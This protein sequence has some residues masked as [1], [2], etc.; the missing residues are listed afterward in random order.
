MKRPGHAIV[1]LTL[2]PVLAATPMTVPAEPEE[3]SPASADECT[4]RPGG[5][6]TQV[7]I[8]PPGL[9][10]HA[11]RDA[12]MKACQS[13]RGCTALIWDDDAHAPQIPPLPDAKM[14]PEQAASIVAMWIND[15][16]EIV[17]VRQVKK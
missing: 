9:E 16:Q 15:S 13:I 10:M 6:S 17:L 12:G 3:P 5:M 7:V 2:L 14:P 8:C 11:W 4:V 1:A